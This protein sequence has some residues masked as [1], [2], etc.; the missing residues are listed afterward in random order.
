MNSVCHDIDFNCAMS[1]SPSEILSAKNGQQCLDFAALHSKLPSRVFL[2]RDLAKRGGNVA[3]LGRTG[4]F[5]TQLTPALKIAGNVNF[6]E[7]SEIS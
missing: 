6:Y 7:V 5:Q 1:Q 3:S 2:L 4:Y